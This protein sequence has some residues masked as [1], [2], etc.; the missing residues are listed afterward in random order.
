MKIIKIP[1]S[2]G[3]LKKTKGSEL[4]PDKILK[5]IDKNLI[6]E[7]KDIKVDNLNISFS[8]KNIEEFISKEKKAIL[9]GGDHSIT[10]PAVKGFSKKNKDFLLIVFDG[11]PDLVNDFSPP[12][13]EDYLRVLIE[14][15]IVNPKNILL[16]GLR[17]SDKIETD[18]IKKKNIK[19]YTYLKLKKDMKKSVDEIS[20]WVKEKNKNIY[21]SIDIDCIDPE[22]APGTGYI[23]K[24]GLKKKEFFDMI[25]NIKTSNKKEIKMVDMVEVNPLKDID[26]KTS[27]LAA[28]IIKI[29]EK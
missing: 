5:F 1:F 15:Q 23:E 3:G 7:I 13:H 12:T 25:E 22:Q 18:Y 6:T 11:H 28:E 26:D 20:D 9:M 29:I 16:I 19:N 2:A 10:Y 17:K 21:L 14:E 27:R 8:H 4:A 24:N